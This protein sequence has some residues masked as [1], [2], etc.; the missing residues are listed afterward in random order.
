MRYEKH[1]Q[2]LK[3][4]SCIDAIVNRLWAHYNIRVE[5]NQ[6][7]SI[8]MAADKILKFSLITVALLSV[9]FPLGAYLGMIAVF[10]AAIYAGRSGSI[11]SELASESTSLLMLA[12][13][14]LSCLDSR[15][16]LMSLGAIVLLCMNLGLY[17]ILVNQLK[18][19]GWSSFNRVLDAGCTLV[20]F[21]GIYQ[22]TSGKLVMPQS[23]VDVNSYGSIARMYSTL[24]NPNI[25]AAYLAINLT[26][27][28]SRL[29]DTGRDKLLQVNMLLAS[30]CLLLSYSRGGYL[31]FLAAM[32]V[33]ILMKKGNKQLVLYTS[34]MT[35]I[36]I[37]INIRGGASRIALSAVYKD[38]SSLYRLEIWKSA[39]RMFLEEPL[40]GYG[41][42]T[43]WYY[44]SN[45]SDKLYSYILHSHNIYLQVAAE[46]GITGLIAF[47]HL[48]VGKVREGI[49]LL[50]EDL[51]ADEKSML[52]GFVA[53]LAGIA[54]HGLVD[55][56]ILVPALSLIFMQYAAVYGSI[57]SEYSHRLSPVP[58][59]DGEGIF[60]LFGSKGSRN[61]KYKEEE[62]DTC[63]A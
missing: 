19:N 49:K 33:L 13:F 60:K 26:L 1:I 14:L 55:A 18:C 45:G 53:C 23:W 15:D 42:G 22:F 37:L 20:C 40:L 52:Q 5:N 57:V 12:S 27:G 43:T 59:F 58:L 6:R 30:V 17:L 24:L 48:L 56:V 47:G 7:G 29:I 25:F 46:L 36:F 28:I 2:L 8:L 31:A 38:S 34:A 44:L 61:K 41:P 32:L 10:I 51:A 9:L 50:R 63:E 21:Y 39:F 62:G 35:V 16:R 3:S 11:I 54:V 4:A